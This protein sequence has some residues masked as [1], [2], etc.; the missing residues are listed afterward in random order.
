[1]KLRSDCLSGLSLS[2]TMAPAGARHTRLDT[3]H[4]RDD[5]IKASFLV[6]FR[7]AFVS[8]LPSVSWSL[9]H[10]LVAVRIR[11]TIGQ[12]FKMRETDE[13]LTP[14]D[15]GKTNGRY[16]STRELGEIS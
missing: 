10:H 3:C 5:T 13:C 4:R 12:R 9:T 14:D 2:S 6:F 7:E 8:V 11:L 1:M 15:C 16:S